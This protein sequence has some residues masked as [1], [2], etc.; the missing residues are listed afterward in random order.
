MRLAH[1]KVCTG[2]MREAVCDGVGPAWIAG[3]VSE[4]CAAGSRVDLARRAAECERRKPQECAIDGPAA[5][6]TAAPAIAPIGPNTTAPDSAPRAAS[7]PRCSSA[8]ACVDMSASAKAAIAMFRFIRRPLVMSRGV[9]RKCGGKSFQLG[10]GARQ[11]RR[12]TRALLLCRGFQ[13]HAVAAGAGTQPANGAPIH[14][15]LELVAGGRL[16]GGAAAALEQCGQGLAM[17]RLD[18]DLVRTPD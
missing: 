8:F 9:T 11:T 7:P 18:A 10:Q 4:A 16:E 13:R 15:K 5:Y 3:L 2:G 1:S 12:G 14:R 6:P 17:L